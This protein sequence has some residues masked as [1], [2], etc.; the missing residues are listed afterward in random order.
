[1]LDEADVK[2][3][4]IKILVSDGQIYDYKWL[5]LNTKIGDPTKIGRYC[6]VWGLSFN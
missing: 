3:L 5:P 1:M 4:M 2:F 6:E